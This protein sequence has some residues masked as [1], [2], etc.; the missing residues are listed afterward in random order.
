[1]TTTQE[2]LNNFAIARDVFQDVG[3]DDGVEK[4]EVFLGS[5]AEASH[6]PV[7]IPASLDGVV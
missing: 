1:M 2:G 4:G 6:F 5:L 3:R 7:D